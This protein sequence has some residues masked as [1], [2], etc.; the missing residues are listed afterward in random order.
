MCLPFFKIDSKRNTDTGH[1]QT[2]SAGRIDALVI[3]G[4]TYGTSSNIILKH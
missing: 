1:F 3:S 4:D 2:S